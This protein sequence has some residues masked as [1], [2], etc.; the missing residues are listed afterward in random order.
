MLLVLLA[1][2]I[3]ARNNSFFGITLVK[4]LQ[5]FTNTIISNWLE[6]SAQI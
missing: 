1:R 2:E 5:I 3:L 6:E 4:S